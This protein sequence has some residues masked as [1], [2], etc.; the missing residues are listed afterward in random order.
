[1]FNSKNIFLKIVF[2]FLL[3]FLCISL[4]RLPGEKSSA[5]ML[6]SLSFLNSEYKPQ[7]IPSGKK[8]YII[9]FV[10]FRDCKVCL[11]DLMQWNSLKNI[12]HGLEFVIV[13]SNSKISPLDAKSYI[14]E[15][16]IEGLVLNDR[17]GLMKEMYH[18]GNEPTIL[19]LDEKQKISCLIRFGSLEPGNEVRFFHRALAYLSN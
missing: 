18:L 13:N 5:F 17:H 6:S 3:L 8:G 1:M 2:F 15:L 19:F 12:Y 9:F 7:K 14:D 16:G 10:D 4:L 11:Q